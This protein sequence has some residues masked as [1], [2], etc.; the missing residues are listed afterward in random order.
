M[1]PMKR[2]M[3]LLLLVLL[4][5]A[6]AAGAYL[7]LEDRGSAKEAQRA[8]AI[9]A[10]ERW[11]RNH[12]PTFVYDGT[13]LEL[14]EVERKDREGSVAYEMLFEFESRHSGYGD[15]EG[16]LLSQVITPHT[17]EIIV[18]KGPDSG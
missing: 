13:G 7:L 18:K 6:A 5:L 14:R 11:I 4:A 9:E 10:A 3:I 1:N 15:R 8:A 16:E 12:S 2:P 17:L